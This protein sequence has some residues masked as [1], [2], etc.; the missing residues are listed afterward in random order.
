VAG[1]GYDR[2]AMLNRRR[3]LQTVSAGLFAA[4]R[5]EAQPARIGFLAAGTPAESTAIDSFRQGLRERGYVE[6]QNVVI[7]FR[8]A[9]GK[10]ERLPELAAVLIRLRVDVIVA[11]ATQAALAAKNATRT[12]PIVFVYVGDPV[13]TGLVT[14][15]ARPGGNATGLSTLHPEF[16]GKHLQ[17]LKEVV[18]NVSRVAVLWNP[19]NP[20]GAP[21]LREAKAAARSLGVELQVLEARGP[22]DFA[23]AFTTMT[24]ASA[25]ALL[26]LTDSMV[27]LQRDRVVD[28]ARKHRLPAIYGLRQFADAGGLLAYDVSL[29]DSARR[30]ASFVDKILKGAKPA[31]LPVEQPTKFDLVINLKTAK[32]LGLTIPPALLGRADHVI[33]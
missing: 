10:Y 13:G 30:A 15:L 31:D 6:A 11:L 29:A 32:A 17:L 3:F 24:A 27:F 16:V 8:G 9:D 20:G 23:P 18:P 1:L 19:T 14:S 28:L 5:A 12:L 33:E 25:G 26:V 21:L 7:E 4:P 22:G 2:P